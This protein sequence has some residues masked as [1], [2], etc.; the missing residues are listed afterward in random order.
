MSGANRAVQKEQTHTDRWIVRILS[1]L[2]L[3]LKVIG[4]WELL[5]ADGRVSEPGTGLQVV[6]A[7]PWTSA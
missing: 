6:A 1:Y 3:S 4:G 7:M 2:S 5:V